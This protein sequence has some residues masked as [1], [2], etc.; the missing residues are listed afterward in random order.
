MDSR[1]AMKSSGTGGASYRM[2]IHKCKDCGGDRWKYSNRGRGI[3]QKCLRR[4]MDFWL[5][6]MRWERW[7]EHK[8]K[9]RRLILWMQRRI[10]DYILVGDGN[11]N[12]P[13]GLLGRDKW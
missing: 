8:I 5:E 9:E 12:G 3:C 13:S 6:K 7:T 1:M 11:Y 2:N 4:R 10:E